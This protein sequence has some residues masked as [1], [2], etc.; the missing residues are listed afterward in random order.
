MLENFYQFMMQQLL[1]NKRKN[2]IIIGKTNMDEFAMGS[3]NETS[4][5]GP[6]LN[7]WNTKVA[8]GSSGGSAAAVSARLVPLALASDTGGSIRQPSAFCGVV[9]MKPTYGLISRFG[10]VAFASS[11]DQMDQLLQMFMIMLYF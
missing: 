10:L 8:G 4:Y 3:T 5:F 7:P 2:M 9:G 6:V 11:L 1:K